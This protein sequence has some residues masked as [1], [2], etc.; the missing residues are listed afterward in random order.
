MSP[1]PAPATGCLFQVLSPLRNFS[2]TLQNHKG[3]EAE[4]AMLHVSSGKER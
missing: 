2:Q 4:Y 3:W 1:A